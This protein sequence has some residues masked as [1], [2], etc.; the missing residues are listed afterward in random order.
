LQKTGG[1]AQ[2]E[3]LKTFNCG[4]GMILSVDAARADAL[5]AVLEAEG[6]TVVTLGRVTQSAGMRYTGAL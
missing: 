6:E 2:G 3:M 4:I 5:R 1:M